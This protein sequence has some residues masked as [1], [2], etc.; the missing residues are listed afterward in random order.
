MHLSKRSL[1]TPN[2]SLQRLLKIISH[3]ES[4]IKNKEQK[5]SSQN[6]KNENLF[7]NSNYS[8]TSSLTQP[9]NLKYREISDN[10]NSNNHTKQHS[11]YANSHNVRQPLQQ[12]Y[13]QQTINDTN[14]N[15]I[16]NYNLSNV[17]NETIHA[18][19]DNH[20]TNTD[21]TDNTTHAKAHSNITHTTTA[22]VNPYDKIQSLFNRLKSYRSYK[23]NITR[24]LYMIQYQKHRKS[25]MNVGFKFQSVDCNPQILSINDEKE[26]KYAN[27][28]DE[29]N[30][31]MKKWTKKLNL[32]VDTYGNFTQNICFLIYM[33]CCVCK[34]KLRMCAFLPWYFFVK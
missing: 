33:C 4:N 23:E 27:N 34:K 3:K 8:Y 13:T 11:K 5:R 7:E 29:L 1:A 31:I 25:E 16:N 30:H 28:I 14:T 20:D 24:Q 2:E 15:K 18:N 22:Y 6:N 26:I 10:N 21:D 12:H 19:M 9:I 17:K 32:C